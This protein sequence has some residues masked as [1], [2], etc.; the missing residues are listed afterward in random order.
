MANARLAA[1]VADADPSVASEGA[2]E[3]FAVRR[4]WQNNK[5]NKFLPW[6]SLSTVYVLASRVKLGLRLRVIGFDPQRDNVSH[7]TSLQHSA[8]LGIWESG[9]VSGV[10][11][12][13]PPPPTPRSGATR[14]SRSSQRSS[15]PCA[16]RMATGPRRWTSE[17]LRWPLSVRLACA[18]V[19]PMLRTPFASPCMPSPNTT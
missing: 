8:D 7:L 19:E 9:Y 14:C 13:A 15:A 1:S 11:N 12:E 18:A 5:N 2:A 10:W 16:T 4:H 17:S 6:L 3:G